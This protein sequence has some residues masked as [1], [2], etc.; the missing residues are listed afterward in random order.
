MVQMDSQGS[1]NACRSGC[2]LKRYFEEG[3]HSKAVH[4]GCVGPRGGDRGYN[5]LNSEGMALRNRAQAGL[6]HGSIK[7]RRTLDVDILATTIKFTDYILNKAGISYEVR[8]EILRIQSIGGGSGGG[9]GGGGGDSHDTGRGWG[10]VG[11]GKRNC[12]CHRTCQ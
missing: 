12:H 4:V 3:V 5:G 11:S 10:Y 8:Y 6:G 9:G 7:S 1:E 2:C